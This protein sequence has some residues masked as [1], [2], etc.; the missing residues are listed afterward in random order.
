MYT[1]SEVMFDESLDGFVAIT[2]QQAVK[3]IAFD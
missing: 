2:A 1:N 3:V